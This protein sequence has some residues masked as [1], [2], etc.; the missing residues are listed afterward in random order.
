MVDRINDEKSLDEVLCEG[1]LKQQCLDHHE[2]K[3][4]W[5]PKKFSLDNSACL[6]ITDQSSPG[7]ISAIH[8]TSASYAKEWSE[9]SVMAGYGFDIVWSTGRIWSFLAE[10]EQSC[11]TWVHSIN[12]LLQGHDHGRPEKQD[13]S[14]TSLTIPPRPAPPEPSKASTSHVSFPLAMD[15]KSRPLTSRPAARDIDL[16]SFAAQSII[17]KAAEDHHHIKHASSNNLDETAKQSEHPNESSSIRESYY[18]ASM[19]I[20]EEQHRREVDCLREEMAAER[21][22]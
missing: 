20:L 14:P 13:D 1:M 3:Y 10:D 15:G 21:S 4:Q 7:S 18:E 12:S 16:P 19:R 11:L 17:P 2:G 8:L 22:R 6:K 9:K 5:I